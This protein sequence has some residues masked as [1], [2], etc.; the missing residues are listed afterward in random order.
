MQK[1]HPSLYNEVCHYFD[2]TVTVQKVAQER[3]PKQGKPT[4]IKVIRRRNALTDF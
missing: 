3:F 1:H 2:G 4:K